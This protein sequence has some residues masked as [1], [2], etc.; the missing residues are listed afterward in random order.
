MLIPSYNHNLNIFKA[1]DILPT[2][3]PTLSSQGFQPSSDPKPL[4]Q[5]PELHVDGSCALCTPIQL[6]RVAAFKHLIH[7][8][9]P[10][11]H[12]IPLPSHI[13]NHPLPLPLL[14]STP[15][16]RHRTENTQ[17]SLHIHSNPLTWHQAGGKVSRPANADRSYPM[18]A[19][20]LTAMPER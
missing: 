18:P 8:Y 17:P 12:I 5:F 15:R 1:Q 20:T 4:I 3:P 13:R 2:P 9:S 10:S 11:N 16:Y 19:S 6:T 14:S 7:K